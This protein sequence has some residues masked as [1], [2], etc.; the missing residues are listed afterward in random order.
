MGWVNASK[1]G[2]ASNDKYNSLKFLI[3]KTVLKVFLLLDKTLPIMIEGSLI[4][5][6]YQNKIGFYP[7]LRQITWI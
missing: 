4:I 6:I 1:I 2:K 5:K 7:F 3:F